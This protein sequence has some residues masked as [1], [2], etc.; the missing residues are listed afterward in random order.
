MNFRLA[1]FPS[2][3]RQFF[4][5]FLS[6]VGRFSQKSAKMPIDRRISLCYS[7]LKVNRQ[8]AL[9]KNAKEESK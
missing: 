2:F 7:M 6:N 4:S 1:K 3:C 9:L 5:I 8:S